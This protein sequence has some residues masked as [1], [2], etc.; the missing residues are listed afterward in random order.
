M[1]LNKKFKFISK[2]QTLDMLK[3]IAKNEFIIPKFIFFTKKSYIEN[4]KI[5]LKKI[6][7]LFKNIIIL[8]SSA[9]DEDQ[10]N[11]SNAGQ[12]D[13][14]IIKNLKE[15]NIELLINKIIKKFKNE[16]DEILVQE[17]I[18]KPDFSGV[19]FTADIDTDAPYYI[20]NYDTSGKSDLI[21]SGR[22]N[23]TEKTVFIFKN[24][25]N[26]QKKF[27]KLI[28]KTKY[29]E[30]I[31]NNERL[32]V[33]FIIKGKKIYI[34]QVRPLKKIKKLDKK[35]FYNSLINIKKKISKFKIDKDNLYGDQTAFSNMSD[36]NPAEMIGAKAKKLSISL[37]QELITD[38]IWS[39]QRAEYSYLNV[40]PN[41]LM[42][43]LAGCPYIN[44]KTDFNSFLPKNINPKTAQKL[45]KYFIQSIKKNPNLHDKIE[46]NLIPTCYSLLE[47]QNLKKRISSIEYQ[48]YFKELR[49]LSNKIFD[50]VDGPFIKDI[51]LVKKYKTVILR[52]KTKTSNYVNNIYFLVNECKDFG[53]RPFA[54][55][56]RTAF[57]ATSLLNDLKKLNLISNDEIINFYSSIKSVTKNLSKDLKILN[58]KMSYKKTFLLKYGHLRP[59]TYS[60][61]S[62]NYKEGF[63][64]YFKKSKFIKEKNNKNKKIFIFKNVAKIDKILK[65]NKLNFNFHNLISI[66]EKAIYMREFS[67]YLFTKYI[68][69]IFENLIKLSK[70]M[71][72]DRNDLE[73]V[74]IKTILDSYNNL[75][76]ERL[77]NIL[78]EEIKKSKKMFSITKAIKLPEVIKDENDVFLF[79]QITKSGN[80]ITEKSV[81]TKKY[82]LKNID[83]KNIFKYCNGK[84]IFIE[85]ADPGYDFLF[86]FNISGLITKYGGANSHMAI[87]CSE[88]NIPAVIGVGEKRFDELQKYQIIEINCL[89]KNVKGL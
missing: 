67:K 48:K 47:N 57:I 29:L 71:N 18:S 31:T 17:F 6:K 34:L 58:Q 4:K 64:E 27:F 1:S 78:K 81:T 3:K 16:K 69:L 80:F 21:T 74:S 41:K 83:E 42:I 65:K 8:R 45:I 50:L 33:E 22:K 49:H 88:L 19:I 25:K 35:K 40:H 63:T 37:Y 30:K 11:R 56:A 7:A 10:S 59:S 20:I 68:D 75:S 82:F 52:K 87:R 43:D 26:L 46:F 36:W 55:I 79:E 60:I 89:T 54:G 15:K 23:S 14:F 85:N 32:D 86:N 2:A 53:T 61:S 39:K 28:N 13:S 9:K 72:I 12:Y 77:E 66:S 44:L 62:K 70:K 24:H 73:Y 76:T 51:E 5:Y 84:I 38:T